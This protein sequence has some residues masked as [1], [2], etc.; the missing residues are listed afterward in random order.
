VLVVLAISNSLLFDTRGVGEGEAD[1]DVV[2]VAV[3]VDVAVVVEVTVVVAVSMVVGVV[4][5]VA[6]LVAV[7]QP[8]RT[9]TAIKK[10][11]RTRPIKD[12][13]LVDRLP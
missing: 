6:V 1:A 12:S 11:A 13:F 10:D 9:I 8:A 3:V 7:E 5:V 2:G 4:V